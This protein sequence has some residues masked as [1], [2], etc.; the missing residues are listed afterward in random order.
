MKTR[1]VVPLALLVGVLAG[2]G[3]SGPIKNDELASDLTKRINSSSPLVCWDK[4][5]KLGSMSAMGYTRVCGIARS[6]P[7]VYVRTGTADKTGWCVVTPRYLA[8]PRCPLT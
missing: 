5:G 3:G 4:S 7:S 6:K 8:A 1:L 2:C